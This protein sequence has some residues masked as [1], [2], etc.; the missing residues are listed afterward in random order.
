MSWVTLDKSPP[1]TGL[2]FS[3]VQ[4]THRTKV[5]L[6]TGAGG[7]FLV[8][9]F[10]EAIPITHF[11][12][13]QRRCRGPGAAHSKGGHRPSLPR[14][15]QGIER[16]WLPALPPGVAPDSLT[17]VSMLRD[18][19]TSG[20]CYSSDHSLPCSQRADLSPVTGTQKSVRHG[21]GRRERE[22]GKEGG[23]EELMLFLRTSEV[24]ATH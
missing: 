15:R 4:R 22:A 18:H 23:R 5:S 20:P 12:L 13:R 19:S 11:P 1:P 24:N 9:F 6:G 2:S 16:P 14:W 10:L 7:V 8:G 17:F 21:A 3:A